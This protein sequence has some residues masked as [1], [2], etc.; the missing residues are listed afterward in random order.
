MTP[1][2]APEGR[3]LARREMASDLAH[4]LRVTLPDGEGA[5]D[6]RAVSRAG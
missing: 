4:G 1:D 5:A 3:P 2:R 6:A